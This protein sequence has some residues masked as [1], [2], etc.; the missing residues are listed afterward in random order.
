V[1]GARSSDSAVVDASAMVA[2]LALGDAALRD[3]LAEAPEAHAPH[4]IDVEFASALRG[5]VAGA[6]LTPERA[7]GALEDFTVFS[8]WRLP[9]RP[10]LGRIWE[11]REN[12]SAYDATYVAL[13]EALEVPLLTTDAALAGAGGHDAEVELF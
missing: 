6:K 5:L 9:H 2:A 13:S 8:I 4:L 10:L 12:L 3:R 7:A 1:P 11:L